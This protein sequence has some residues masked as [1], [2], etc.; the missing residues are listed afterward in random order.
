M[1]GF[2]KRKA[3]RKKKYD[4]KM[5]KEMK[6]ERKR[7]QTELRAKIQKSSSNRCVPEIEH[8]IEAPQKFELPEHTVTISSITDSQIRD[9]N[10][11][12]GN[13]TVSIKLMRIIFKQLSI[14]LSIYFSG[15]PR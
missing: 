15:L 13:N 3:E 4:E 1:T 14:I 9:E 10:V 6:E 2:R 11:F 12:L 8:L 7:L 5:K